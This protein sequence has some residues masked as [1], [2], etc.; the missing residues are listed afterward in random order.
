[1]SALFF[2]GHANAQQL[3]KTSWSSDAENIAFGCGEDIWM[4]SAD[5]GTALNLTE[6]IDDVCYCPLFSADSAEI[7]FSQFVTTSD[8][9]NTP[10]LMA[11]N[12][13]TGEIH[14]ILDNAYAVSLSR[15]GRYA[16]YI[17]NWEMY[18]L[19]DFETDE[20]RLFEF[21]GDNPPYFC[22]GHPDISPDNS[23]FV[24]RLDSGANC[25]LSDRF[26]LFKIM[27]GTGEIKALE[28]EKSNFIYPKYSVD[29]GKLMFS[30]YADDGIYQLAIKDIMKGDQSFVVSDNRYETKCGSW[31][32]EGSQICFIRNGQGNSSLEIISIDTETSEI[33]FSNVWSPTDVLERPEVE[34]LLLLNYPNPFNPST[35]IDFY[36]PRTSDVRLDIFNMA[37]QK[38]RTL[39]NSRLSTGM[40]SLLWD[41]CDESGALV[42]S[43][44]YISR[45]NVGEQVRTGRMM[46]AR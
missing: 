4:I 10:R 17:K 5:G 21:N 36:V 11:K 37:G 35:T 19:Y 13:E 22:G 33:L 39:I 29:G 31:S 15:D 12:I 32:P 25:A 3:W 30:Q 45:L 14:E 6:D 8:A 41:G 16:V 24:V 27:T 20:E 9:P 44:V 26:R 7:M 23:H 1:M 28:L 34:P 43:G 46:L 42:S 2:S 38:I 40:Q 18:A